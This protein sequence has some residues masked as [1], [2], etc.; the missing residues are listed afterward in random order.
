MHSGTDNESAEQFLNSAEVDTGSVPA[1][2]LQEEPG[3]EG[4]GLLDNLADN[5]ANIT[6]ENSPSLIEDIQITQSFINELQ[7]AT[8]SNGDISPDL[9]QTLQDPEHCPI[10][11]PNLDDPIL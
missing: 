1:T 6:A 5:K 2:P 4:G 3:D 10:G 7:R 8:L 11:P 9:V